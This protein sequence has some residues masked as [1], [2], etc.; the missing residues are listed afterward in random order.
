M[1]ASAPRAVVSFDGNHITLAIYRGT[2]RSS[3]EL[4]P[5]RAVMLAHELLQA[6][7]PYHQPQ[8]ILVAK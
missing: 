4:T 8:P 6:A 1:I 7:L 3:V 2:S 5:L